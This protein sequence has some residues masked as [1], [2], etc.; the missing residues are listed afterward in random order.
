M[1]EKEILVSI[2]DKNVK[3]IGEAIGNKTCNKILELLADE[4][5]SATD[6][7]KKMK[8]SPTTIDYAVK[9]LLKTGLISKSGHWWSV[10]GKKISMYRI[11]NRK[12]IISPRKSM[13]KIFGI[14]LGLTGLVGLTIRQFFG[15][16]SQIYDVSNLA[17]RQESVLMAVDSAE[18]VGKSAPVAD[19][20]PS[21]AQTGFFQTL[22][23][24]S[25][26][27]I[28]AWFA[29]LLFFI[30]TIWSERREKK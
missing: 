12:I 15:S 8:V 6:L 29:I 9:K 16:K 10:K 19:I 4:E 22:S 14:V 18:L 1:D 27:L 26:F 20:A 23:P 21:V 5:M 17:V 7:S 13:T 28:G 25:W 30:V 3:E 11:S 2:G 24:W